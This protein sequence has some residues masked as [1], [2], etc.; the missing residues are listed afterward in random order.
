MALQT[1]SIQP[2]ADIHLVLQP[3]AQK[4]LQVQVIGYDDLANFPGPINANCNFSIASSAIATVDAA[5]LLTAVKEG[6]TFLKVKHK[7]ATLEIVARVWVHQSITGIHLGNKSGTVNLNSDNFQPTVYGEFNGGDIEDITGHHFLKYQ[8]LAPAI[9]SVDVTT[10]RVKGLAIG[11]DKLRIIDASTNNTIGDISIEVTKAL[12]ADRL[13][14]EKVTVKGRGR[15]KRN[16]I[17]LGEGFT[18]GEETKF[19]KIVNSIDY[20]MRVSPLHEPFKLLSNDYNTW[21]A[22]EPSKEAG[23]SIGPFLGFNDELEIFNLQP[24]TG[25]LD[26]FRLIDL[27]GFP[28]ARQRDGT[29]YTRSIALTEWSGISG[30]SATTLEQGVFDAWQFSIENGEP[31]MVKDSVYGLMYGK[32]LGDRFAD[33]TVKAADNTWFRAES[34]PS[35][36]MYKDI[37]RISSNFFPSDIDDTS[38]KRPKHWSTEFFDYLSSLKIKSG[39]P[40]GDPKFHVGRTWGIDGDDESLVVILVNDEMIGGNYFASPNTFAALTIGQADSLGINSTTRVGLLRDHTPVTTHRGFLEMVTATAIHELAHGLFLGDEYENFRNIGANTPAAPGGVTEVELNH[41]LNTVAQI[42]TGGSKWEFMFNRVTK[43]SAL[44][45]DAVAG[46]TANTLEFDLF[47]NEISKWKV[48]DNVV[49]VTKNLNGEA[50]FFFYPKY[51]QHP[52][53]KTTPL[54]ITK[55]T[56]DR[57]TVNGLTL[58]ASVSFPK[59][60]MMCVFKQF[61]GAN[62]NIFLPGVLT[63]LSNGKPNHANGNHGID[64]T[65]IFSSKAGACNTANQGLAATPLPIANVN[66]AASEAHRL[67]GMHE[68]GG[69]YNCGVVRAT[70]ACKMRIVFM[71]GRGH[72]RFCHVCKYIIVHEFNPSRHADLDKNYPGTPV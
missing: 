50:A 45:T 29:T 30:I 17:F 27:V 11:N 55:I 31:F 70:A 8:S 60:S 28:T 38:T 34:I 25:N 72:F 67:I 43:S 59:G 64:F 51:S 36:F 16:I 12:N 58:P 20:R 2:S 39:I 26:V 32:R 54:P 44:L 40:P 42:T 47:P 57:V 62:L 35:D 22:F 56:G 18:S 21:L 46:A 61:N 41:N 71:T 5:G 33:A 14:V 66:I 13:L 68:G 3:A 52:A 65:T 4:T 6:I 23:I 1:F 49:L 19:R 48:G 24:N 53:R 9:F 69:S 10:G 7:T 37:R 15:D 63:R